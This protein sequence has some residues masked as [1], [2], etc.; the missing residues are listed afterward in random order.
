MLFSWWLIIIG[1]IIL[2]LQFKIYGG[3][4]L[5]RLE[6]GDSSK[7]CVAYYLVKWGL[8]NN[9]SYLDSFVSRYLSLFIFSLAVIWQVFLGINPFLF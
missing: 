4:I 1:G 7:G 5:S 6:F 2:T 3:C 8:G 9:E